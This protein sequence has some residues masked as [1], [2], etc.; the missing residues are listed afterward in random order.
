MRTRCRGWLAA[1][2]VGVAVA[3]VGWVAPAGA[4]PLA[5]GPSL[6]LSTGAPV[7]EVRAV[8]LSR[9]GDALVI[10]SPQPDCCRDDRPVHLVQRRG[11][12]GAFGSSTVLRFVGSA[13][14]T[15]ALQPNGD[16]A[17]VQTHPDGGFATFVRRGW[18]GG[19]RQV[20]TLEVPP[21]AVPT[22]SVSARLG[23]GFDLAWFTQ[24]FA[25]GHWGAGSHQTA[26]LR[27]GRWHAEP[28][29]IFPPGYLSLAWA[30]GG[31]VLAVG[32]TDDG[33]IWATARPNPAAA[34]EPPTLLATGAPPPFLPP[35]A[36]S[37]PSARI[38]ADGSL[39]ASW[40]AGTAGGPLHGWIARR[41]P[42]AATWDAPVDVG[43]ADSTPQVTTGPTGELAAVW[44]RNPGEED[45]GGPL[46]L[47]RQA[48]GAPW[49]AARPIA[50]VG[51]GSPSLDAD[52]TLTVHVGV[53][54]NTATYGRFT[55][56]QGRADG[57]VRVL[58]TPR[59]TEWDSASTPRFSLSVGSSP[60]DADGPVYYDMDRLG[61]VGLV[62]PARA[63]AGA[64]VGVRVHLWRPARVA[65]T[66][67]RGSARTTVTRRLPA[68]RSVIR[69]RIPRR[70]GPVLVVA[71]AR[72]HPR[73]APLR[74]RATIRVRAR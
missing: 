14:P 55:L 38:G 13:T 69:M 11:P 58:R 24:S 33:E 8:A 39:L 20:D 2:G 44:P 35:L 7:T 25:G 61:P 21:G 1:V 28:V 46:M 34:W 59:A 53:G 52:G 67:G 45:V 51:L 63:R 10:Y 18:T 72:E 68:G 48:P 3:V 19:W 60:G 65:V 31:A 30:Q 71:T 5:V 66:V 74:Q 16:A 56:I 15:V 41:R 62:T 49:P 22:G 37:S 9:A 43:I 42:G 17:I 12:R 29:H 27:D 47:I 36:G 4:A 54:V 26:Q 57:P 73:S 32:G 23:G 40:R 50:G 64:A 70:T 6:E